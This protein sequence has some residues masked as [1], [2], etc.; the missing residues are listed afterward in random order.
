MSLGPGFLINDCVEVLELISRLAVLGDIFVVQPSFIFPSAEAGGG[1]EHLKQSSNYIL[2]VVL[3]LSVAAAVALSNVMNVRIQER[4]QSVTSI[5]LVLL[6]GVFS[7]L[8]SLIS[9]GKK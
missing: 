4:N 7:V 2:G 8:L 3:S 6:T 1:A 9:T 5:H